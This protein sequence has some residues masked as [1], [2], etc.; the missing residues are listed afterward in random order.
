[1]CKASVC[2]G[3]KGASGNALKLVVIPLPSPCPLGGCTTVGCCGSEKNC[4]TFDC[5][6]DPHQRGAAAIDCSKTSNTGW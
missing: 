6:S 3:K 1:M 5:G 4:Y 2:D